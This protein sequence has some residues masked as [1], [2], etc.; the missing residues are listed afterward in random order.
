MG[1]GA[2]ACFKLIIIPALKMT[3]VAIHQLPI[4]VTGAVKSTSDACASALV[5]KKGFK[6]LRVQVLLR[7]IGSLDT[8]REWAA[9]VT[10][11]NTMRAQF[12]EHR[13]RCLGFLFLFPPPL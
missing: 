12:G 4:G 1:A 11:F 10:A 6:L 5:L 3:V 9:I 7:F 8:H 13:Q 2:A